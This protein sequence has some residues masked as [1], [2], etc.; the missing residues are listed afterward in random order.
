MSIAAGEIKFV[1]IT[2]KFGQVMVIPDL[3]LT[4][5]AGERLVLLGPSGCGKTTALRM[6]AGLESVSAGE[7]YLGG[8]LAN[9]LE[10][11]E[12]EVAMVFQNYALYPHM[13]IWE[14]I[15][16]GLEAKKIPMDEIKKRFDGA[17]Q[18]LNLSGLENR[19]P[20][21]LS[22][23]Q[24]QRVALARAVVKQA[25][26]F[27]LDEPLSNLDAQLR[28]RARKELV[29][30]HEALGSTMVYVTHDQIEAMTI[31]QWIAVMSQGVLQQVDSPAG[32]YDWPAN[33]FVARFIG[34]PPM[35]LIPVQVEGLVL[36]VGRS[37]LSISPEWIECLAAYS[38]KKI[39][40]GIR[41]E[42][43]ELT[44]GDG[45]TGNNVEVQV[46][47]KEHFGNQ[48]IVYFQCA[49]KELA[50]IVSP[51]EEQVSG[52][53]LSWRVDWKHVRMFDS[54]S[55]QAIRPDKG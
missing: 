51:G 52:E 15:A 8:R 46:T 2:K 20:K 27:L 21:E 9:E 23:G 36:R 44:E 6:I 17:L 12:R 43:V 55:G 47:F 35:N 11:G 34:S 28:A 32:I 4:I 42:Y 29:K 14:N 50:A 5:K 30:L 25:P 45:T 54:E 3:S 16:F 40:M 31:G 41:P 18:M 37:L 48:T 53:N 39:E 7:L 10:P 33:L 1:N 38:G 49:G 22:G 24:R 26:Y 19:K 13:T